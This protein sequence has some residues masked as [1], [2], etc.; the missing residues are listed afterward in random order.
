MS[1]RLAPRR[2][3]QVAHVCRKMWV[4]AAW[5]ADRFFA[6]RLTNVAPKRAVFL[7]D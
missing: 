7:L 2:G 3:D 6:G 4:P 5:I 1:F